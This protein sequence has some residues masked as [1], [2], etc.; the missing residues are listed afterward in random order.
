MD[1]N[2][3][4]H[5]L[6]REML[7]IQSAEQYS[8][9]IWE[10]F[11]ESL[12]IFLSGEELDLLEKWYGLMPSST[13]VSL[14][15]SERLANIS[16]K[17]RKSDF[18]S[19]ILDEL[20]SIDLPMISPNKENVRQM[21]KPV[22]KQSPEKLSGR[23]KILDF[24][25]I[26]YCP[27][28]IGDVNFVAVHEGSPV[29]LWHSTV[30]PMNK[31]YISYLLESVATSGYERVLIIIKSR[32]FPHDFYKTEDLAVEYCLLSDDFPEIPISSRTNVRS[33][34]NNVRTDRSWENKFDHGKADDHLSTDTLVAAAKELVFANDHENYTGNK[35][36]S[37][38]KMLGLILYFAASVRANSLSKTKLNK[39][40]FYSDFLSY[41]DK[42]ESITGA[43]YQRLTHG[44]V[45][46]DYENLLG[47]LANEG[48]IYWKTV[49]GK[50]GHEWHA[51]KSDDR[52]SWQYLLSDEEKR[53]TDRVL[54]LLG[55]MPAWEV[56]DLSH[57]EEAWL[58]TE[59][60]S[61]ISYD[62]AENLRL[63]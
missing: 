46:F 40:S 27:Q 63:F 30:L 32:L 60:G 12:E 59:E 23:L 4:I 58:E 25:G 22:R 57:D 35:V 18:W 62:H 26:E 6:A 2:L 50:G 34:R 13:S 28:Q 61:L 48:I 10:E 54:K 33:S 55:T 36:F 44:P 17:I 45:I 43:R 14:M 1:V 56:S 19:E 8:N 37:K 53:T 16:G 15:E 5:R 7:F 20:K 29:F 3:N 11:A 39:L 24:Y 42:G 47:G 9:Q 38:A 41:K 51:V 52:V 21:P 31:E 49:K